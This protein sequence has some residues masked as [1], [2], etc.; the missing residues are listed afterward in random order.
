MS[1][2]RKSRSRHGVGASTAIRNTKA[3]NV[4]NTP[5]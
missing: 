2:G 4:T 1:A 5:T 3:I